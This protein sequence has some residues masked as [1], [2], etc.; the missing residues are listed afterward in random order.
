[1]YIVTSHSRPQVT[2]GRIVGFGASIMVFAKISPKLPIKYCLKCI[3]SKHK[4]LI[5][6]GLAKG[7]WGGLY[8]PL[9]IPSIF[10]PLDLEWSP[11]TP[12]H[13]PNYS[14]MYLN[15]LLIEVKWH[16]Q[17]YCLIRL[18]FIFMII[19]SYSCGTQVVAQPSMAKTRITNLLPKSW[20]HSLPIILNLLDNNPHTSISNQY[21]TKVNHAQYKQICK[22]DIQGFISIK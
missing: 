8:I 12:Q 3:L 1:M 15:Y 9:S 20:W 17:P 13:S 6:N 5:L 22:I 16:G 7:R 18:V 14:L 21:L 11:L 10:L 19:N 2:I 4:I